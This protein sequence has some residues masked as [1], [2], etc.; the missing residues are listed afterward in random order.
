MAGATGTVVTVYRS[1]ADLPDAALRL[2][3]E[4]VGVESPG[5]L[6]WYHLLAQ[7]AMSL[8]QQTRFYVVSEDAPDGA[9][10]AV[11]PMRTTPPP[12]RWSIRPHGPQTL[13]TMW[14]SH[15]HPIVADGVK[16]PLPLLKALI[17]FIAAE[18]HCDG[19]K[20]EPLARDE[21]IFEHLVAASRAAGLVVQPFF[22]FSNWYLEV[23]GRTAAQV[24]ADLTP[25]LAHTISQKTRRLNASGR[26]RIQ[27]FAGTEGLEGAIADCERV[28]RSGWQSD[29]R[30]QGFLPG[31]IRA[32]ANQGWMR[33]AIA[34]VDG[35]P[36]AAQFW[37]V[38][39]PSALIFSQAY[40]EQHAKLSLGTVLMAHVMQH[41]VDVDHVAVVDCLQGDDAYKR[42]WMAYRRERWGLLAMNPR[43]PRGMAG[44]LRHVGGRFVKRVLLVPVHL[45]RRVL[46]TLRGRLRG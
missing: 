15:C 32:C 39:S 44:V 42:E 12:G 10:L 38:Q 36:A 43:T 37:I 21:P 7:E 16:D 33:L 11:L 41:V 20:L 46:R 22:S 34:Y 9:A 28:Y 8:G 3:R 31:L 35:Q 19:F 6:A 45:F 25:R 26:A 4:P 14:T 40:D 13:A 24:F 29:Q 5:G 18:P 17:A 30:Y 27:L 23:E 2:F 1:L